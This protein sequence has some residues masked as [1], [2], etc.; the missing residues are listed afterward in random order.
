ML[1][2]LQSMYNIIATSFYQAKLIFL[3]I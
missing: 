2:I 1:L 3:G